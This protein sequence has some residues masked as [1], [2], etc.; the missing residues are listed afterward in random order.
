MRV[1]SAW[2]ASRSRSAMSLAYSAKR[3]GIPDGF[4][5]GGTKG[6]SVSARSICRSTSR[7]A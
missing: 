5:M 7:T 6:A 3:G 4:S 1:R 2:K